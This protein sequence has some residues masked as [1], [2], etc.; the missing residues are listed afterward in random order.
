MDVNV[1]TKSKATKEQ[2]FKDRKQRKAKSVVDWEK[3]DW[4]K[5]SM[6]GI[7]Q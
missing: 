7:I 6:V 2:V 3:E 1:A 5:K 4:L